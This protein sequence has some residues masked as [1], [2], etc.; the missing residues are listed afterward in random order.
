MLGTAIAIAV[1]GS[2]DLQAERLP[3]QI[4]D[5]SNGLAHNR[6]RS[7]LADSR[8]FLW[9]GTAD[10]L[11][12]FDGSR[13]VNYGPEQVDVDSTTE[14]LASRF[15]DSRDTHHV[16]GRNQCGSAAMCSASTSRP[17]SPLKSRHT[18]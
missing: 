7:V 8:G 18:A 11:S 9:F 5:A 10:G 1:S 6:I 13:F 4:H 17:K 15:T 12:R 2:A 3:L 16:P 14:S